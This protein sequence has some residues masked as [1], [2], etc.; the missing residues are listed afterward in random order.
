MQATFNNK[1]VDW[2]AKKNT[3]LPISLMTMKLNPRAVVSLHSQINSMALDRFKKMQIFLI[4]IFQNNTSKILISEHGW[5][6]IA[7][8][9]YNGMYYR[10]FHR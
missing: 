2:L 6:S 9:G 1:I 4:E 7:H 3:S 8:Q 5:F 10:S